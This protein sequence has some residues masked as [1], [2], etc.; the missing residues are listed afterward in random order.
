MGGIVLAIAMVLLLLVGVLPRRARRRGLTE[1][2]QQAARADSIPLVTVVQV[3]RAPAGADLTL[4]GTLQ[5]NHEAAVYARSSGY[6]SRWYADIGRRV[7]AGELLADIAAPD[8]DQQLAQARQNVANARAT[9]QLAEVDLERWKKLYHDS[10]VTKQ[11]LDQH[12]TSYDAGR[13]TVAAADADARRVQALVDYERV[14][15]PF[16]GVVTA[17]NVENGVFVTSAGTVS[18]PQAAGAGGNTLIGASAGT[19]LFRVARTDTIRVYLGVPQAY[20]PAVHVGLEAALVAEELPDRQFPGRV[21]RTANSVDA[22]SRT[23]LS[24]VDVLNPSAVLLPGMYAQVRFRFDRPN[25]PILMPAPALIFRTGSAQAAVVGSDSIAHFRN[26]TIGRDYGTVMEVLSGLRDSDYVVAQPSDDLR[27]GQHIHAKREA[28]APAEDTSGGQPGGQRP[29]GPPLGDTAAKKSLSPP[30]AA[31]Q[32]RQRGREAQPP[33][34][35][36]QASQ[37]QGGGNTP[38]NAGG[39]GGGNS[40]YQPPPQVSEGFPGIGAVLPAPRTSP[41]DPDTSSGAKRTKPPG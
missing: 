3:L 8:L 29:G 5:A 21:A 17:R 27:D 6:V 39:K 22:A 34:G 24:E 37:S 16:D 11:E 18:T 1:R 10:T 38:G 36:Q 12:Q 28:A 14:T 31:G 32:Q 4:P 13:A 19:E 9:L 35:Q 33:T 15:A 7:H 26:L 2:A 23:L 40:G 25:P 41:S 20:A 30:P